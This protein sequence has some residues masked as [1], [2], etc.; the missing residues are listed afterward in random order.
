MRLAI[1]SPLRKTSLIGGGLLLTFGYVALI[2]AQFLGSCSSERIDLSSLR[3]A[4][5]LVPENADYRDLVGNYLFLVQRSPEAALANYRDAVKLNPHSARLW[6]DLSSAFQALGFREEQLQALN[7][8]VAA[9]PRTP[10]LAWDAANI[11]LA[12]G[13][14]QKALQE[15]RVVL[16]NDSSLIFPALGLSRRIAD[17]QTILREIMPAKPQPYYGLLEVLTREKELPDASQVWEQL[18]GLQQPLEKGPVFDYVRFLL[19]EHNV[20]QAVRVWQQAGNLAGLSAY[21]PS[22][23]NLVINGDFGLDILNGGFGWLYSKSSE[24]ALALDP[25]EYHTSHRSLRVVFD[26]SS[27]GD[28]GIRQLVAVEPGK[29]YEFS[30]FY[31]ARA[32]EGAGGVHLSVLDAYSGEPFFVSEPLTDADFWKAVSGR[33]EMSSTGKLVALEIQRIPAGHALRGSLWLDGLQMSEVRP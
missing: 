21:Q 25:T 16:E 33:F 1:D 23:Q 7:H 2:S 9:D 27:I 17:T 12:D 31:K 6:L 4:S 13:D 10:Q 22:R 14:S 26:G 15:L 32:M 30:A 28:A 29:T 11:Y 8:A 18:A 3:R 24:V 19:T 20:D 5:I